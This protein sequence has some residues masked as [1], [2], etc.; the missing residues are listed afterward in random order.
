LFH[1][2]R[3]L[4]GLRQLNRGQAST[5][6]GPLAVKTVGRQRLAVDSDKVQPRVLGC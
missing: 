1:Q 2:V 4:Y 5:R 3:V 6:D